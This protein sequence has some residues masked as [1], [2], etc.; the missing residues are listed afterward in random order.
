V[1]G[2]V[3]TL[4]PDGQ[5]ASPPL[6]AMDAEGDS[7]AVWNRSDG[8]ND[9][10]ES[11][12]ISAAGVVS[13]VQTISP[14]GQDSFLTA[15]DAD[16]DG[17]AIATWYY[18]DGSTFRI[19]ARQ[20]SSTDAL[21]SSLNLTPSGSQVLGAGDVAMDPSGDAIA[22]YLR[23][24]G[25]DFRVQERQ[26]SAAGVVG[27]AQYLSKGGAGTGVLETRVATDFDGDA[28]AIWGRP[29][30]GPSGEEQIQARQVSDSGLVGPVIK[31][32]KTSEGAYQPQIA[33]DADGDAVAVWTQFTSPTTVRSREISSAGVTGPVQKLGTTGSD[34]LVGPQVATDNDNDSIAVWVNDFPQRVMAAQEPQTP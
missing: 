6:V 10:V 34:Y 23:F 12:R 11:R 29:N 24:D 25:V 13:P 19:Q 5:N 28:I 31:L 4:S 16:D 2:P 7:I 27:S 17:D 26:I 14:A 15:L 21:G 33:S 8:A 18:Y 1:R 32:S 9:R 3:E 20:I 22:V 30:T